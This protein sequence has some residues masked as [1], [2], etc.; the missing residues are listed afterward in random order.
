MLLTACSSADESTERQPTMLTIYVYS[1]EHPILTRSTVGPITPTEAESLV[2]SL[3][4]W[5][6]ESG[7]GR[8][9][10][11]FQTTETFALNEREGAAYQIAVDD[12]F[13]QYKPDVD[14]YVLANVSAGN[15]GCELDENST[16]DDLKDNAVIGSSYF[17][18]SSLTTTV[19]ADG[20]PMAGVLKNQPVIGDAP[21]LRIG[22]QQA[23]AT[24]SLER[25]VSKLRFVFANTT[26]APA[27][28][29]KSIQ[30]NAGMLPNT[31]YLIPQTRTL[32]YN[33]STASLLPSVIDAVADTQDPTL[34]IYDGREAQAYETLIDESGLTIVGPYYLRESDKR[35]EGTITY[36]IGGGSVQQSTFQMDVA[37][38][39]LRNHSWMVYAYHA[40]G[41]YLQM[42]AMYIK[43]WNNKSSD[44]EV[45]NW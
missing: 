28:S 40:G 4:I 38:D 42:S 7:T 33:P 21:V 18:L 45:Y 29:I 35:L 16:R 13:A 24:V 20:L 31:E 17:G 41:G 12:A 30:L 9:V 32:Y 37:G 5:I 23:I 14:V 39:F 10:G 43:E 19:P 36:T 22:T 15:C 25:A 26:G 11:Y 34:Y 6:F 44:H 8:K 27:L 1:P 3:Q 2:K